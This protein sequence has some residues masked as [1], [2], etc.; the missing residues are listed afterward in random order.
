MKHYLLLL[1]ALIPAALAFSQLRCGTDEMHHQLFQQHPE[2]NAGIQRAYEHSQQFAQEY[3]NAP[4]LKSGATYIIPVVFHVI[5]NYGPENIS[6]AQIHDALNQVNLQFR[7][8][9]PDTNDI[10]SAFQSIAAD[11]Q[12]RALR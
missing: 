7:K 3:A 9:N 12:V 1:I 10:V 8:L 6:D 2:Y 11:V 5:H 4:H